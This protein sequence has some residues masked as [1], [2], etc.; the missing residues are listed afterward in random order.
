MNMMEQINKAIDQYEKQNN[1]VMSDED[2]KEFA[3]KI[4]QGLGIGINQLEVEQND[5]LD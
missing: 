4:L 1:I 2:R 3:N 5:K